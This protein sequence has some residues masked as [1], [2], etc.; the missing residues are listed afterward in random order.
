M[1]EVGDVSDE[2]GTTDE[3]PIVLEGY[4]S[5]DFDSFLKILLPR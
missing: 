2:E 3:K 4:G 1:F 5:Q